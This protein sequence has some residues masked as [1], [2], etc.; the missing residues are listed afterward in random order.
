[1]RCTNFFVLLA[2]TGVAGGCAVDDR[3]AEWEFVSAAV[4][5]P[6]CATP[7]CHSEAAAV[8]GLDFS[9]APRGYLSLRALWTWVPV[10]PGAAAPPG[11]T[12]CATINGTLVCEEPLRPLVTP[13]DPA[14]SRVI[15][16]MRARGAPRMPPD[17]PLTEADIQLVER[18]I[19]NGACE[20]GAACGPPIPDAGASER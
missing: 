18:W 5:Q 12:P 1:M 20:D 6:T 19:L 17:R 14:G 16:M 8:S 4:F 10:A 13:Y 3:P 2:L 11:G 15:N 7:S 9:T